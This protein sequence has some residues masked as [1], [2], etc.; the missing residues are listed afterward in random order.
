MFQKVMI[1]EDHE[2][3]NFSVRKIIE[4]NHIPTVDYFY[5]C[6]QAYEKLEKSLRSNK[7]YDLLITDLS[8]EED[9]T[10]Q[11]IKSG[12]EL[13]TLVKNLQ[14]KLKIIVFS[15][16]KNT[17]IIKSLFTDLGIDA[18]VHK[19]RKDVL[20]LQQA[21]ERTF[22]E[23]QFISCELENIF[24][25]TNKFEFTA[26]DIAMLNHLS[27]GVLQKEIPQLLQKAHITPSSLSS[28]EKRLSVLR[29]QLQ[30]K[31]N[32]QLVCLCKDIGII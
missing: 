7:A 28:I 5:Y 3:A 9:D 10:P 21:L 16:E 1:V 4:N 12:F 26:F 32:E 2:S 23:E 22:S 13:I 15:T 20:E 25:E 29:D 17:G 30:V 8:F 19:G 24:N 11:R 6:D 31:N 18:F 14:P 27:T